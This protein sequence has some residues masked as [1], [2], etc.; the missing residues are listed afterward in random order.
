MT[1]PAAPRSVMAGRAE[2]TKRK[3]YRVHFLKF[4]LPRHE[5]SVTIVTE[6]PMNNRSSIL[7]TL[8]LSTLAHADLYEFTANLSYE[9]NGTI[10]DLRI[11]MLGDGEL[12][13]DPEL[14]GAEVFSFSGS[15]MLEYQYSSGLWLDVGDLA[16]EIN[17]WPSF[18]WPF[19]SYTQ[20]DTVPPILLPPG[21]DSG[22]VTGVLSGT[23]ISQNWDG[24]LLEG[25]GS[26]SFAGQGQD[27]PL[28]VGVEYWSIALVPSPGV[29][30]G[31][32]L[33]G[34]RLK[35]RRRKK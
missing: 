3:V 27:L 29:G 9:Q 1:S 12:V 11:S 17:H 14:E 34:T 24:Q 30:L 6:I 20:D 2:D 18:S 10:H 19:G 35:S 32:L 13:A 31:F 28:E 4:T 5:I 15:G 22:G 21:L 25:S 33:A 7:L 23:D 16:V 26:L 8:G